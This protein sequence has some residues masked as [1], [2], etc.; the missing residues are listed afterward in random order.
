MKKLFL[1]AILAL[2]PFVF[3]DTMTG[4][5][6]YYQL[7]NNGTDSSGNSRTATLNGAT[8]TTDRF[9]N[10]NSA[11]YFDGN[12]YVATP[13]YRDSYNYFTVAAWF[14]YTGGISDGYRSIVASSNG[15]FFVGKNQSN[16]YLGVQD[17][18]T[19]YS[20][21]DMASGANPWNGAWHHVV[22]TYNNGTGK[23]YVDGVGYGTDSFNRGG[24]QILIGL[25]HISLNF[26][27][28]GAIDEVR[29]YNRALSATDVVE[30][31][32]MT[33]PEPSSLI[34]G[35]LAIFLSA[36]YFDKVR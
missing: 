19:Y 30:V 35:I 7:N 6:A 5:L 33:V 29:L 26:Y 24:G 18:P 16:A 9:G 25:E 3:S 32:N 10:A 21:Q 14:R 17:N 15:D 13:L 12:D 2:C 31:F 20:G 23:I 36:I 11:L 28:V 8:G 1:L 4:L 27:F 22:Y 34:L